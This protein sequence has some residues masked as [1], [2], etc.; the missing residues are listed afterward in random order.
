MSRILI[1]PTTVSQTV[2]GDPVRGVEMPVTKVSATIR[3]GTTDHDLWYVHNPDIPPI[4]RDY[5]DVW[6]ALAMLAGMRTGWDVVS[7]DPASESMVA[8]LNEVQEIWNFWYGWQKVDLVVPPASQPAP[9][10]LRRRPIVAER[11][12][13]TFFTGGVDSFHTLLRRDDI[14]HVLYG[15]GFEFRIDSR[16]Q[17]RNAR[18]VLRGVADARGVTVLSAQTNV[19]AYVKEYADWVQGYGAA[20]TGLAHVFSSVVDKVYLPAA[21]TYGDAVASGSSPMLDHWW[22]SDQVR[23]RNDGAASTRFEKIQHVSESPLA[24]KYLRVC[25]RYSRGINCG[26]CTKCVGA[27]ISLE[28]LGRL[29]RCETFPDTLDLDLVRAIRPSRRASLINLGR[30]RDLATA[31]GR[32]DLSEVLRESVESWTAHFDEL[33]GA[34]S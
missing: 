7:T 5:A 19:R 14:S 10:R 32:D 33:E 18:K 34:V 4:D 25:G 30:F 21:Y 23:I 2:I 13:G 24:M 11:G 27:M 26:E 31:V 29:D 6:L 17:T 28:I 12:T 16:S 15:F 8:N 3:V 1:G 9:S 20:L 22:S